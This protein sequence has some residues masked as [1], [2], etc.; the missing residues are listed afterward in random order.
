MT[1]RNRVA[2]RHRGGVVE[3]QGVEQRPRR[4]LDLTGVD[5]ERAGGVDRIHR[6]VG[7]GHR[8]R[9]NR[10]QRQH[11]SGVCVG[12]VGHHVEA[13]GLVL[14]RRTSIIHTHRRVVGAGQIH[15]KQLTGGISRSVR[16]RQCK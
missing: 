7:A 15:R 6:S 3:V 11:M 10:R 5:R 1:V 12:V 4:E 16:D 2:H 14:T 13:V 9:A 8:H